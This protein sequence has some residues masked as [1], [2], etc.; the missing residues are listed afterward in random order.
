MS[1]PPRPAW[2]CRTLAVRQRVAARTLLSAAWSTSVETLFR[3]R[4][5]L[6]SLPLA[7]SVLS[8]AFGIIRLTESTPGWRGVK[9]VNFHGEP[10]HQ[11]ILIPA[12]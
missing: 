7:F 8:L 10:Q 9:C 5:A 4:P 6:L 11:H 1:H 2:L 3:S 12:F